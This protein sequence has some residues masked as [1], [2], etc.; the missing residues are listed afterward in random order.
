MKIRFAFAIVLL[1]SMAAWAQEPAPA[2]AS[3]DSSSKA[4]SN[5]DAPK[6]LEADKPLYQETDSA[7]V[8]ELK[9]QPNYNSSLI[10]TSPEHGTPF[11]H[12]V[13]TPSFQFVQSVQ[14]QESSIGN[15]MI[16]KGQSSVAGSL[17]FQWDIGESGSLL[18]NGTA[19]WSP[20]VDVQNVQQMSYL[21]RVHFGRWMASFTDQVSY[22]PQS[23]FGFGGLQGFYGSTALGSLSGGSLLPPSTVPGTAPNQ[24]ILT[25]NA[26]RVSNTTAGELQ[27]S[28][29]AYD[30]IHFGGSYGL[31]RGIDNALLSGNQYQG[32]A[33]FDH[34]LDPSNT[35]G[36]AYSYSVF[37]SPDAQQ[38]GHTNS[39]GVNW[40]R[41]L[42][43][44]LSSQAYVG[45]QQSTFTQPGQTTEQLSWSASGN[46]SYSRTR[47]SLSMQFYHGAT[48]GS[49]IF[50]GAKTTA[51]SGGLSRMLTP[52]V[53]FSFTGGYAR[54][55]F[56]QQSSQYTNSYFA[57]IQ[58]SHRLYRDANL[59]F[60]YSVTKQTLSQSVVAPTAFNGVQHSFSVGISWA[61]AL[62][63]AQ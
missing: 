17:S 33:G 61:H 55:N 7:P 48:G 54:N 43:G 12:P 46:L 37:E 27:Y 4:G 23:T 34:R 31:I 24:S 16:W 18:Y 25:T 1:L 29:N 63:I 32:T 11:K 3:G 45:I 30:A 13:L 9:P 50:P 53:S 38:D 21:Q 52:G 59:F 28:L 40:A 14:S 20:N 10:A 8:E 51:V 56:I 41:R 22:S 39:G 36:L 60:G 49:G 57:G 47:N 2:P 62:R 42:T 35:I 15:G 26:N 19:F 6:A 5:S 58:M 44:R